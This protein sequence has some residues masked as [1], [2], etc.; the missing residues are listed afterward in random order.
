MRSKFIIA[1]IYLFL[2][3]YAIS[4]CLIIRNIVKYVIGMK[5]Y[6]EFRITWFYCL[7]VS[8][9]SLRV[10]DNIL[11]LARRG[12]THHGSGMDYHMWILSYT[13]RQLENMI[14]VQ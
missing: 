14:G 11:I 12:I 7:A 13:C 6:K 10:T 3:M 9:I 1:I 2:G 4:L 5:R 8:V